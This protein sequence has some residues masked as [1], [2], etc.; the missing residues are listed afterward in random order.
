MIKLLSVVAAIAFFVTA[1]TAQITTPPSLPPAE[2]GV[3]YSQQLTSTGSS[4][5]LWT[6][7]NGS[8]PPGISLTIGGF[9]SG[10]PGAPGTFDAQ[11]QLADGAA[12]TTQTFR[13]V[14]NPALAITSS[15][16]LP[17]ALLA[18]PYSTTLTASGGVAPYTWSSPSTLPA[19]L[20]L[21]SSG[22]ISG[23]PSGVGTF[24]ITAQ[25]EDSYQSKQQISRTF[26]ITV[27]SRLTITTVT[28]PHAILGGGYSFSLQ[29][30]GGTGPYT[31]IVSSGSIPGG[32]ALSN[33]GVISGQPTATSSQDLVFTVTDAKGATAVK[34]F[35]FVVDP[36]ISSFSTSGIPA[37]VRPAQQLAFAVQL[38]QPHP[39]PLT[40]TLNLAFS[41]KAEVLSDDP[42]TLFSNGS[43]TVT[44]SIPANTTT[45]TLTSSVL[46][47]TGT[48]AGTVRFTASID[49]GPQNQPVGT[50]DIQALPPQISNVEVVRTATGVDV[51]LTGYAPARRVSSADFTFDVKTGSKTQRVTLTRNVDALFTAWFG[52]VASVAYGSSFSFTQSFLVGS[53]TIQS[54]TV[55][56]KNAQGSTTSA[57]VAPK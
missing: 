49:N 47:M 14:V 22:V 29:A 36:A 4:S 8:L 50:F 54:V 21:S 35:S 16:P 39:S 3:F 11:I 31:W 24:T 44:F 7:L 13:L 10:V 28:V 27:A 17:D 37:T 25:V 55:T 51:L 46:L 12:K 20:T 5:A 30:S 2:V 41:S 26:L 9:M 15:S 56:L 18:A 40:G 19:G 52:N 33:S 48:V 6:V 34:S 42:M 43:R 32:L 45:A 1:A 57:A 38:A 23:T 53:G